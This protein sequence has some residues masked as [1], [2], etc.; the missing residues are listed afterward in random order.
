[1][2]GL[3]VLGAAALLVASI[4][5]PAMAQLAI[6]EPGAYQQDR[7]SSN[8]YSANYGTYGYYYGHRP[9]GS[10]PAGVGAGVVAGTS[11]SKQGRQAKRPQNPQ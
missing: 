7:P 9:S 11:A 5:T 10:G 3:R 2:R 6:Q 8:I 1:M 4:A